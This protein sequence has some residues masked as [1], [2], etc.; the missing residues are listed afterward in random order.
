M[1]SNKE[2]I[3]ELKNKI[4]KSAMISGA[5]ITGLLSGQYANAQEKASQDKEEFKTEYKV[6]IQERQDTDKGNQTAFFEDYINV[7]KEF[8]NE[9][10]E[11]WQEFTNGPKEF[12]AAR[13]EA[14]REF[15]GDS[16]QEPSQNQPA[17]EKT[18][19]TESAYY[20]SAAVLAKAL[21]ESDF[22]EDQC[23]EFAQKY[24]KSADEQGRITPSGLA[25][26]FNEMGIEENKALEV[27]DNMLK[28]DREEK[29]GVVHH[30]E[31][32]G[33]FVDYTFHNGKLTLS[34]Y[35]IGFSALHLVP[36]VKDVEGGYQC[37]TSFD[38]NSKVAK[39]KEETEIRKLYVKNMIYN[40]LNR[41][42]EQGEKLGETESVFMKKYLEDVKAH[43]LQ[44]NDKGRLE[45]SNSQL[46]TILRNA[47]K[48]R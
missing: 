35:R 1:V 12:I 32:N 41:R 33:E 6:Q 39:R 7:Q 26:V 30:A 3:K 28:Y 2:K 4:H 8:L 14:V 34:N 36:Q 48:T 29:L 21:L 9:R 42:A 47:Q 25:H 24:V 20:F 38:E 43:G 10:N 19:E 40:D 37:G 22:N 16:Q 17:A 11:S 31:E 15:T 44:I 13:Q 23:A 18:T 46:N 27:C 5:A 45:N